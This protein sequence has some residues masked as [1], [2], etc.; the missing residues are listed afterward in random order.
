[1]A[2]HVSL[3]EAERRLKAPK[4]PM[5]SNV[6]APDFSEEALAL[7]F[8]ELH[9]TDLRFV[10]QWGR[11]LRWDG[12]RWEKDE[13]QIAF[14]LAR[15]LCRNA[16]S[17]CS[18]KGA[19]RKLASAG[20]VAAVQRLAQT[21]RRIAATT[22]KFDA[23]PREINTPSGI[24][25]LSTGEIR[26]HDPFA[27]HSKIT[28]V[29]PDGDCPLWLEFLDRVMDGDS[30]MIAYLR[31]VFGYTLSGLTSEHCLFFAHGYGANGKSTMLNAVAGL[32][33]DY[34][35]TAMIETFVA[36]HFD[37]HPTELASL[38]GARFVTAIETEEGRAWAESRIKALTGGDKIAARFMRR[39][40]F[41]F[42][43]AFKL[44]IGGNHRPQI[45]NVDEAIRR[46]VHL[47]PFNVTIPP[48][49][50]DQTLPDRLRDEWPG[51]FAWMIDG[52]LDWQ[53]QG[54]APPQTVIDATAEYLDAQDSFSLWLEECC[55]TGSDVYKASSA[56]LW[57]SWSDWAK[58]A[59][60][61][62]GSQKRL[63]EALK[64]RGFMSKRSSGGTRGF[65]GIFVKA[66]EQEPSPSDGW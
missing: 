50:R 29:A 5:S 43:P 59:G 4:K 65:S 49:E 54:L 36:S 10:A 7:E 64:V 20:T 48:K 61:E 12:R 60:E 3:S 23:V 18:Q 55:K 38:A 21:D 41:E 33:G 31:R 16:A 24:V 28:V 1:M 13:T 11:W 47:I 66:A 15:A 6:A 34:A 40:P 22:D 42:V 37:R 53:E 35:Q 26:A 51:I 8:A 58:Q 32:L 57:G 2:E 62:A 52:Y 39:D 25:T 14:D 45:R 44:F 46:R 56:E 19:A 63:A 9:E 27:Y 30:E 17:Q